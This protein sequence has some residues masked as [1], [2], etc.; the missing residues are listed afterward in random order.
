MT[1]AVLTTAP[2]PVSTAQPKSA[3]SISGSSG[4][5][6]TSERRD[7]VAYSANARARRD[8]DGRAAVCPAQSTRTRE[9]RARAVRRRPRLAQ[10]RPAFRARHAMA[11]GRHEHA[12]HVVAAGEVVHARPEL[13]HHAR[14]LVPERHRHRPW[15]V[16]VD[17][18]Q[19]GV[20]QPGRLDPAPALRRGPA[21]AARAVDRAAASRPRKA[22]VAPIAFNT[23]ALVLHGIGSHEHLF[24]LHLAERVRNATDPEP[25]FP[26]SR[27]RH[28]V[29]TEC[30]MVVDHDRRSVQPR[31]RA[32]R[33]SVVC[34]N[35]AA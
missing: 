33:G 32:H 23:A 25:G 2:T 31:V 15:P 30:G 16:A 18:R 24:D 8:D 29:H 21:P 3:A 6:L 11:A 34:V 7:T 12:Y 19:I 27:K 26:Q 28:P 13:L 20:T 10:R 9:Q 14:R 5:I 1:L 35:T 22:T 4:S 17:H